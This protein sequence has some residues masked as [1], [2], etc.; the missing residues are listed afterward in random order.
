MSAANNSQH[1]D[2]GNMPAVSEY[3]PASTELERQLVAMWGELLGIERVGVESNFFEMG[4]TSLLMKE[5]LV[6]LNVQ[7]QASLVISELFQYPNIRTL[8]TRLDGTVEAPAISSVQ[9]QGNRR[10]EAL[11]MRRQLANR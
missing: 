11:L 5:M 1:T 3:V 4:G 6:R 9:A 2:A 8:A 10:R 7:M